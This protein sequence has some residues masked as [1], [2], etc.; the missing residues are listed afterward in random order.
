MQKSPSTRIT[1]NFAAGV[2]PSESRQLAF[3]SH[4]FKV[5]LN[6]IIEIKVEPHKSG[7]LHLRVA[8]KNGNKEEK[9]NYDLYPSDA[10]LENISGNSTFW[11]IRCGSCTGKSQ[12]IASLLEKLIASTEE[13]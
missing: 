6:K 7:R 4:N 1:L 11:A 10:S 12:L 5:P 13:R 9:K 2:G 3:S 8:H